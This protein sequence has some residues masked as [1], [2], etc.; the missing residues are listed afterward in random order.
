MAE[1][2]QDLTEIY[3]RRFARQAEYRQGVWRL[4]IRHWLPGYLKGARLVVELGCGHGEFINQ[5]DSPVRM[6]IDLNPDA[7]A[8]LQPG[9]RFECQSCA[10]RWPVDDGSVDLVFTS[11]FFEHL[12]SKDLLSATLREAHRAL[13]SGGVLVALGPNVRLLP[14]AYWD[15]WDHHL[16]LTERSLSEVGELC[17]FR[18]ERADA[19]TLP[20][21]MSQGLQPPLWAVRMYLACPWAWRFLGKQFLVV[22]RK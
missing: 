7:A 13:R 21:S 16:A 15:F 20:Y 10:E 9:V 12:P 14:G 3:R 2:Q 5:I 6:G 19:A 17:G 1:T 22:M 4:L 8:H 18:I 11:N